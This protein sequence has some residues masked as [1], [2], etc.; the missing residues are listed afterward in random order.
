[1][2]AI[3]AMLVTD[4]INRLQAESAENRRAQAARRPGTSPT[5]KLVAAFGE[6]RKA[7][8]APVGSSPVLPRL[9][10]YPFSS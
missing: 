1:M 2:N 8:T 6:I 4:H 5:R 3:A 7:F 9:T 10:D